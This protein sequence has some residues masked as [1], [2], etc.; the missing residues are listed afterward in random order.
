MRIVFLLIFII[1]PLQATDI[2]LKVG[3][4]EAPPL[5]TRDGTGILNKLLKKVE[6]NSNFKFQISYMTYG[7]AIL[8]LKKG[9]I[10]LI[11]VTPYK[12]ETKEFY[13]FAQDLNWSLRTWNALFYNLENSAVNDLNEFNAIGT[14]PGNEEFMSRL[15]KIPKSRF[16]SGKLKSLFKML[17]KKRLDGVLFE[18]IS[19]R[20][21]IEKLAFKS[22]EVKRVSPI[23]ASLS[24]RNSLA[25]LNPLLSK[26]LK[27][28]SKEKI[29]EGYEH[30]LEYENL[31]RIKVNNIYIEEVSPSEEGP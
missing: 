18:Y 9:R 20:S 25:K 11:G 13:T 15:Y 27:R 12:S 8:E 1:Q 14:M 17:Q 6:A 21:A 3:L 7:R 26:E 16:S 22:I 19:A 4:E 31:P 29:F 23:Y 5:I 2:V 28:A 30:L 24:L 10:D